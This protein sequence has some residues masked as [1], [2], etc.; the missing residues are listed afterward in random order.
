MASMWIVIFVASLIL[1]LG[2]Y[3]WMAIRHRDR[4]NLLSVASWVALGV[5]FFIII[6][7]IGLMIFP[8]KIQE[9]DQPI[10]I[11]NQNHEVKRGES[12][13][14]KIHIKKYESV[15]STVYPSILCDSGE[16]FLFPS[17]ASNV[18]VGEFDFI[19][20][21]AYPIP[22][23]VPIGATCHT[24]STDVFQINVLRKKTYVYE[25]EPFKIIQ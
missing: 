13:I 23:D 16:Y 15:P 18:P 21:D 25:S 17:R 8:T 14:L 20:N 6:H 4:V 12:L 3:F 7:I 9:V 10:K 1:F 24:R 2:V 22:Y 19:V 5:A 11:M